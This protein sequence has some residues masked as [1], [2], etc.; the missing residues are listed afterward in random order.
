ME[1]TASERR[2]F[3]RWIPR[4]ASKPVR[5]VLTL[6]VCFGDTIEPELSILDACDAVSLAL[7]DAQDARAVK[8]VRATMGGKIVI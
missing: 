7:R 4:R 6:D 8:L 5:V 1:F 3:T 2:R